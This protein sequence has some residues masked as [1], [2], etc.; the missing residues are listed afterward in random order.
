VGAGISA[1]LFLSKNTYQ[2]C[3]QLAPIGKKSNRT[4]G[5]VMKA[6][7]TIKQPNILVTGYD[8][9]GRC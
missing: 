9:G 2:L 5:A 4:G 3:E 8:I 7:S 1:S 6:N